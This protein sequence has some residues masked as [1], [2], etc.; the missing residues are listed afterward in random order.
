VFTGGIG[1]HAALVRQK[2]AAQSAWLGVH[3]DADANAK[4]AARIDSRD[5]RVAVAVVPTNEELMIARY[6]VEQLGLL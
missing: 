1:E 3:I 5:S 2:V 6:T 4:D